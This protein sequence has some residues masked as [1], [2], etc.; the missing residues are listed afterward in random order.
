MKSKN[1]Q[2]NT[3]FTLIETMVAIFIL[4]LAMNALMGLISSSLFSARYAR[5]EIVAN[6]LVQEAVDYIRN[7]RDT[8]ALQHY[9]GGTWNSFL[10][11]YGSSTSGTECF[12]ST[13]GCEIEPANSTI[14]ACPSSGC[15]LLNYDGNATNND[16]Y[17]YLT[18]SGFSTTT[19]SRQVKMSINSKN[20]D[21]LDITITVKW[22]NGNISRTK[23]LSVSLLNWLQ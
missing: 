20:A 22:K 2:K 3:G 15:G 14:Q 7:D 19:F 16:F 6:Y 8:T 23:T 18:P 13:N 9:G 21:E 10:S 12:N 17:T 4:T 11:K 1:L 5:N